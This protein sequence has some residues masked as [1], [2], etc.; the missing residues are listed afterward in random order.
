MAV[1][2]KRFSI[3]RIT[4][5]MNPMQGGVV[6]AVNQAVHSFNNEEYQ[7][8]VLCLDPSDSSWV[9]ENYDYRIYALGEGKTTY[10]FH[11]SYLYWL[12]KNAAKY[13]V[14]IIDGLWQFLVI[15][16]FILKLLKVPYCIFI[17]GMLGPYF[18]EDK[19]KY[20]KKLPFWFTVERNVIAMANAAIFTCEEEALLAKTSFPFYHARPHIA[21]LGV[22][23]NEKS[24][25]ELV[26]I[27]LSEYPFLKD[28]PFAIFLSRINKI[29]GINLLIDGLAGLK[30]LP[31]DY[32]LVIAG[33]DSNGLQAELTRQI[34][35]LGL[36]KHVEWLGM[37]NG[38]VK[39]GAYH[40]ADVFIL[41]SHHENFGI[42]VTEALSTSTPVLITNKVNIWRE[43]QNGG[44]G[45]VENDDIQGIESLLQRWFE[46][47]D[48][49]KVSMCKKAE[50][51]YQNN[52]TLKEAVVDLENV[53]NSVVAN[54]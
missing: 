21:T 24:K 23:D 30:N 14:V 52:F 27:F 32:M 6:E 12:W 9:V 34:E 51:C 26:K 49:E 7:M 37:L 31:H 20:F 13:D 11:F 47:S 5:S 48:S 22:K 3:L 25:K 44:A 43:I 53:L 54:Q 45:F 40:A 46:L 50:M 16:G 8:D 38:D 41:P 10:G 35:S 15:G 28:K 42:V 19:L 4:R 29:K 33:P 2:C 39:W 18:N 1:R 36:T 17:H